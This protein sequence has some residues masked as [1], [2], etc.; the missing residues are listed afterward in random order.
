MIA[1]M[2]AATWLV[3]AQ[4]AAAQVKTC[5]FDI[6]EV[7]EQAEGQL[8]EV[9][10]MRG[11]VGETAIATLPEHL[12][13]RL[14]AY[15][16][17]RQ[18]AAERRGNAIAIFVARDESL[19]ALYAWNA[20]GPLEYEL[21]ELPV[22]A[23]AAKDLTERNLDELISSGA[24]IERAPAPRGVVAFRGAR[25]ARSP[26]VIL[27]EIA[28]AFF[29]SPRLRMIERQI[30]SLSIVP[31]L[32]I[33]RVPFAALDL[34]GDGRPLA[35]TTAV[36]V[37][38]SL[39]NVLDE[40]AFGWTPGFARPVVLG[41]PDATG[42]PDWLLPRLPG[43]RDEADAVA[44]IMKAQAVTD[45]AATK[46]GL[47]PLLGQADYVH[48]AAHG[49][50]SSSNPMDGGFVALSDGR[51][52]ARQ[53]QNLSLEGHPLVVLSA[54]QTALGRPL[55]GGIVGVA[56]AFLLAGSTAVVASLWN[57]DDQ[58]TAAIMVDFAR[59]LDTMEP[60]TALRLAQ[61]KARA[62]NPDPR[63]WSAFMLFGGRIVGQ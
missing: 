32:D 45:R 6:A 1:A 19:C 48:I 4:I 41:D 39:K 10:A 47:L 57:V 55:E 53:I 15:I 46:A 13:E 9:Y 20:A 27:G 8:A 31:A 30:A 37:E 38:A 7:I 60:A 58:A 28:N 61:V 21:V 5:P 35:E 59:N 29:P 50:A 33:G 56:R 63:I 16:G 36:N 3:G 26:D 52:T 25:H 12:I 49:I 18:S 24:R 11:F 14:G 22:S 17:H 40:M 23:T 44:A 43:A 54:C 62:A 34:D 2:A 51:L 42:D